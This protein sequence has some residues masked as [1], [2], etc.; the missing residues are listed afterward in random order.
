MRGVNDASE[1]DASAVADGAMLDGNELGERQSLIAPAAE[2][3]GQRTSV[4]EST[5]LKFERHTGAG[6]FAGSSTVQNDF[7]VAVEGGAEILDGAGVHPDRAWNDARVR[8]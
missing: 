2:A 4:L 8:L 3:A 7:V 1:E 6:G 5:L